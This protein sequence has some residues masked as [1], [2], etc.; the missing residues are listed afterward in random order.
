MTDLVISIVP[1]LDP[2]APTVGPAALKAH[3]QDAG[4][5]CTVIDHNVRLYN[6]LETK[7][8]GHHYYYEDDSGFLSWMNIGVDPVTEEVGFQL[9]TNFDK[10][11]DVIKDE[12]DRWIAE[13]K[14]INPTW[15]GLSMLSRFSCA[16][17]IKMCQLIREHIP[18]AKIVL[19]GAAMREWNIMWINRGWADYYIFGDSERAIIELLNGNT[20]YTGI[21]SVKPVQIED[22]DELLVPDYSDINWDDY[23]EDHTVNPV[24]VTASRGCVKRCDFCDVPILWPKYKFRSGAHVTNEILELFNR[25]QRQTIKFTDSLINGSMRAFRE[26]LTNITEHNTNNDNQIMWESQ[27]IMRPKSQSPESD[28]ALMK[29]S[30]CIE[31]DIG[32]ESFSQHVRYDMGKKFTDEDMWWCFEMLDKYEIPYQMLMIVGYPTETEEDHIHTLNTVRRMDELG[33]IS[34]KGRNRA[35]G[36]RFSF[37]NT[38]LLGEGLPIWDKY[39]DKLDYYHDET[40]WKYND[41]DLSTR[42][43][44]YIEVN[45]LVSELTGEEMTWFLEKSKREYEQSLND[46]KIRED[47]SAGSNDSNATSPTN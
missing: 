43:R 21:N 1:K 25:Y 22:L 31:L 12:L 14:A 26:L 9:D 41:N 13:L 10:L 40:D 29:A 28:F 45:E 17:G 35:P 6:Y 34:K 2:Y 37:G 36:G 23:K 24:F 20:T 32:V 11:Y 4:Y 18:T 15:I 5:S 47:N 7:Q 16:V 3:L 33:Y 38:L 39:K 46:K 44:R 30:G 19:G 27:W 42:L 8:L